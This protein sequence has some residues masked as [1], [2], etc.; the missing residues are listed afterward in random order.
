MDDLN[1]DGAEDRLDAL[2]W[3]DN[4]NQ[5]PGT[6]FQDWTTATHPE[7]GEVEVGGFHPK[8][9]SQNAPPYVLEKWAKNEAL[10]NLALAMHMPELQIDGV[11]VASVGLPKALPATSPARSTT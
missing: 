7:L 11:A 9:F 1:G 2:W 4:E 5:G 3:N 10:F 6:V 8:F